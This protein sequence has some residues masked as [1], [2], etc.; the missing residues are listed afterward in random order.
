MTVVLNPEFFCSQ[1]WKV[2]NNSPYEILPPQDYIEKLMADKPAIIANDDF[3]NNLY[4]NISKGD[5]RNTIKM[6]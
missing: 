2:C 4:A 1:T 5:K 6:L 3:I